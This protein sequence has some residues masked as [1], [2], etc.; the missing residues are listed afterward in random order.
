MTSNARFIRDFFNNNF[1]GG[2]CMKLT[3]EKLEEKIAPAGMSLG[4]Q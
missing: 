1:K 3:I 2:G 4:G